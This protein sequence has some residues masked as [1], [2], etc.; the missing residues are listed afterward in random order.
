MTYRVVQW[1]TG[2]VGK[3]AIQGVQSHP[4]L[5]LVGCRVYSSEKAGKD[6][7][8]IAGIGEIGVTATDNINDILALDADCVI[9]T[10]LL[11]NDDEVVQLL[12]SGK[13]VITTVGW[14]YPFKSVN[15][16]RLQEACSKGKS[17]L[18]GTGIHPGGMTERFPMQL[19]SFTRAVTHVRAEEFSDIRTYGAP[20]VIGEIMLFGKK[21]EE[22]LVSPL[23]HFLAN[24]FGQSIHMIADELGFNLDGEI[25]TINEVAVA[26]SPIDSPI[27]VIE[28]GLVAAQRFTWQGCVNGEPVIEAIVNWFMGE[29]HFD[30]P[31]SFGP[32]GVRYEIEVKGDPSLKAVY[33]GFH[34]ATIESGLLRNEGIVATAMHCVNAVPYVCK[35]QPGIRTYLDLPMICGRAAPSE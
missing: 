27:G 29:E 20:D 33:H 3:A 12:E 23:V 18:H 25:N 21:P 10:P 8:V 7:G 32:E 34:P 5:Q 35:A 9:Y 14:V 6:A 1:A 26:T 16:D 31:W 15:I 28:P 24:G 30:K 19:T 4:E 17:V 11:P 22:A 13:N 2:G